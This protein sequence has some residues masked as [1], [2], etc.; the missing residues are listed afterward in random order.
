M[1]SGTVTMTCQSPDVVAWT[2]G[3]LPTVDR[4]HTFCEIVTVLPAGKYRQEHFDPEE[5]DGQTHL[6]LLFGLRLSN[7]G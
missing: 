1:W 2:T 4:V 5:D 7:F 3:P 6:Y